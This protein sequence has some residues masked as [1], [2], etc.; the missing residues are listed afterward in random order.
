MSNEITALVID[1]TDIADGLVASAADMNTKMNAFETWAADQVVAK[2]VN[3]AGTI[4]Q[5]ISGPKT[6]SGIT[7]VPDKSAGNN[8]TEAANT[9]FVTA[10]LATVAFG[11]YGTVTT[12]ATEIAVTE[13][14][15][16]AAVEAATNL[17][18][19][20]TC[21]A[22]SA[23][24][25]SRATFWGWTCTTINGTYILRAIQSVGSYGAHS[26]D[27]DSFLMFVKKGEFYKVT[28]TAVSGNQTGIS[29]TYCIIPIGS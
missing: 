27:G 19:S 4:A 20:A 13:T 17:L 3:L 2:T 22:I 1:H 24:L 23:A 14:D 28:G 12:I 29:R 7:I 21:K 25:D 10:G 6:F 8:T 18:V 16:V 9:K 15:E 26:Q 5:T 11:N